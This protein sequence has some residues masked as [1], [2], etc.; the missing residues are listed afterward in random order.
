MTN[1]TLSI[2]IYADCIM[3]RAETESDLQM[4]MHLLSNPANIITFQC[5]IK[6]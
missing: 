4:E 2:L 1:V 5:K 3:L 6:K